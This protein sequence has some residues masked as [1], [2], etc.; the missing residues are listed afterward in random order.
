MAVLG[1][2]R[3]ALVHRTGQIM[4]TASLLV[5]QALAGHAGVM[6]HVRDVR[7]WAVAVPVVVFVAV[8]N[9]A[10]TRR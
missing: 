7:A 1:G 3:I 4:Q 9:V 6:P 5:L 2:V 8:V 10:R